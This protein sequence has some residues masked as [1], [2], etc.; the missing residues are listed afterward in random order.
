MKMRGA[1]AF[2]SEA[3]VLPKY[4]HGNSLTVKLSL[5]ASWHRIHTSRDSEAWW[6][7]QRDLSRTCLALSSL[8]GDS[9]AGSPGFRSETVLYL[10][11]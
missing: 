10:M 4:L 2:L 3:S 6:K 7:L 8:L 1:H 9:R 11:R 5:A